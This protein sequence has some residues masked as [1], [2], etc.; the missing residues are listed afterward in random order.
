MEFVVDVVV[1]EAK[2]THRVTNFSNKYAVQW[3]SVT[4]H[5]SSVNPHGEKYE[6][7]STRPLLILAYKVGN[8]IHDGSA[9][10][11]V[12]DNINEHNYN[13]INVF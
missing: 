12:R 7:L 2:L 10:F 11:V 13:I 8:Y 5:E 3:K 6:Y 1:Q 4:Q 9:I